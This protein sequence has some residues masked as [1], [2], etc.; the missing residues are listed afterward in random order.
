M[1][2]PLDTRGWHELRDYG[3]MACMK[4]IR[5]LDLRIKEME[6]KQKERDES[7]KSKKD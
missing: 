5:Y 4:L 3:R 7:T 2:H 6:D 1:L